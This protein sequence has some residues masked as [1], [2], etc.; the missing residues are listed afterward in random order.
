MTSLEKL[1]CLYCHELKFLQKYPRFNE[2]IWTFELPPLS[3]RIIFSNIKKF[4]WCLLK[5]WPAPRITNWNFCKNIERSF[6]VTW[7]NWTVPIISHIF[8]VF[9]GG[10]IWD[11]ALCEDSVW[12]LAVHLFPKELHPRWDIVPRSAFRFKEVI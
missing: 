8:A 11:G 9:R 3:W 4:W 7:K 6:N 12:L 1:N 2:V 10:H 5:I